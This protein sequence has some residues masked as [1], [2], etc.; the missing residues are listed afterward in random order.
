MNGRNAAS[1]DPEGEEPGD[2]DGLRFRVLELRRVHGA[3][4]HE[5]RTVRPPA[6][7]V[8]EVELLPLPS[9]VRV[10]LEAVADGVR[11]TG[12]ADFSWSAPCRR[13][14]E[15]ASGSGAATISELFVD[16]PDRYVGDPDVDADPL[17]VEEGWVDLGP[18]VRD[19]MLLGLPL[20]PLCGEACEG[21][22]P[23]SHPVGV[24]GADE[25]DPDAAEDRIDPRWSALSGLDLAA[26]DDAGGDA[27]GGPQAGA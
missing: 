27:E 2:L 22:D 3:R 25:P 19:A 5:V 12:E 11:A 9:E 10:D 21:P 15:E 7:R 1:T 23:G 20:A 4:E 26:G 16:D 8:G 13:C 24:A 14:L 18:P 6:A 17:P